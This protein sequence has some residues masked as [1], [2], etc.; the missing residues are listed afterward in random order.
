MK[1]ELQACQTRMVVLATKDKSLNEMFSNLKNNSSEEVKKY[2]E[3]S[4]K[5]TNVKLSLLKSE[6]NEINMKEKVEYMD[7]V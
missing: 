3:I 2:L 1:D 7:K 4:Q 5:M 6:R